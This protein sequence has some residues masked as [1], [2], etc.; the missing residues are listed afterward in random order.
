[1]GQILHQNYGDFVLSI[2]EENRQM[3]PN[4]VHYI[5]Q[6]CVIISQE[7][8]LKNSDLKHSNLACNSHILN[9]CDENCLKSPSLLSDLCAIFPSKA[10]IL[11]QIKLDLNQE[12]EQLCQAIEKDLKIIEETNIQKLRF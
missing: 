1:M 7:N 5:L 2:V 10:L 8:V 4:E 9:I 11:D 6:K 3:T 12:A